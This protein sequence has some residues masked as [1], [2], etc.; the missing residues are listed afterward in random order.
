M[1]NKM[2]LLQQTMKQLG[3]VHV[4]GQWRAACPL[5]QPEESDWNKYKMVI[6]PGTKRLIICN[7]FNCCSPG[8]YYTNT[9]W[10][11]EVYTR[12]KIPIQ[13]ATYLPEEIIKTEWENIGYKANTVKRREIPNVEALDNI[14]QYILNEL[15]LNEKHRKWLDSK[16][17]ESSKAYDIGYRST[18]DEEKQQQLGKSITKK[19]P[20]LVKIVPGFHEQQLLLRENAIVVP[21]RNYEGRIFGLKQRLFDGKKARIRLLSSSKFGGP[22]AIADC[23]FPLGVNKKETGR[24]WITEGERKADVWW[25]TKNEQIVSIPG[26]GAW[27][28][29]LNVLETVLPTTKSIVLALDRD[30]E[31][32]KTKN[33]LIE[34][35]SEKDYTIEVAEWEEEKGLDDALLAGK[36]IKLTTAKTDT[37]KK[38]NKLTFQHIGSQV[39]IRNCDLIEWI[40]VKGP[41]LRQNINCHQPYLSTL[42]AEKKV[43]MR[44]SENGQIV[45]INGES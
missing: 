28:L 38:K 25:L 9:S 5:C 35:L 42:I 44:H 11:N 3:A 39:Y 29:V 32:Q 30:G 15:G 12:T 6:S 34:E 14:Y 23:H 21:C 36:E 10:W 8:D 17:L 31:G 33:K 26:V 37:T 4:K 7:C 43:K 18:P 27:K 40:R 13:A 22:K 41:L 20:N 1:Y 19:Y 24:L 45:E 16:G 2:F